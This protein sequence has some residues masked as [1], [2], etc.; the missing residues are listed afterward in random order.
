MENVHFDFRVAQ[1][2]AGEKVLCV[3]GLIHADAHLHIAAVLFR[4]GDE[5]FFRVA[6]IPEHEGDPFVEKLPRIGEGDSMG[7]AVEQPHLQLGF[8]GSDVLADGRL[9]HGVGCGGLGKAE[10]LGQGDEVFDL[11]VQHR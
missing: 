2:K 9:R 1:Q 5:A 8:Q 6:L 10:A 4:N 3:A 7:V 11:L